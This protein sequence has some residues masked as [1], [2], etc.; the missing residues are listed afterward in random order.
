MYILSLKLSVPYTISNSPVSE[1]T[2][3]VVNLGGPIN[4]DRSRVVVCVS[5]QVGGG[6]VVVVGD[7]ANVGGVGLGLSDGE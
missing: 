4:R 2:C 3:V 6:S 5:A 7:S 1:G